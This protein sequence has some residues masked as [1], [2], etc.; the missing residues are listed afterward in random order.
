[1]PS[2][3]N[4]KKRLISEIPAACVDETKAVEFLEKQR[5][6][7]DPKCPRC[8]SKDVYQM[9][10]RKTGERNKDFRWRCRGCGKQYTVRTG[11]VFEDSRI[12]LTHWC[13]AFWRACSSKKGVSALQIKRETGLT[14]KSAL[15]LMHRIRWAMANTPEGKLRGTVEVDET[16]VGGKP[17]ASKPIYR[18]VY[19]GRPELGM[20]RYKGRAPDFQDRKTPVV[21]L[22]ERGGRVKAYP[23]ATV[24]S[25][26]VEIS[27]PRAR[28]PLGQ[29]H[30]GRTSRLPGDRSGV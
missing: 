29:D 20:K 19:K 16:Y 7:D 9:R 6:C 22:V 23:P 21:A 1:M 10:D 4:D 14:Y 18:P 25:H 17:R 12:A 15:F 28:G 24:T 8:E 5:W 2:P 13:L 3:A 30:H 26:D 27:N 11:T